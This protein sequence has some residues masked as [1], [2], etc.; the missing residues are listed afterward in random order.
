MLTCTSVQ[1]DMTSSF[2]QQQPGQTNAGDGGGGGGGGGKKKKRGKESRPDTA[3]MSDAQKTAYSLSALGF[4]YD[5]CLVCINQ[6]RKQTWCV[7]RVRVHGC[8]HTLDP[9]TCA[10]WRDGWV[11]ALA[12]SLQGPGLGLDS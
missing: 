1:F 10:G 9:H 4:E 2:F 11:G 6:S 12:G 7:A 8:A 3:K 5:D